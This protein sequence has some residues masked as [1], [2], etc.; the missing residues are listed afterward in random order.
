MGAADDPPGAPRKLVEVWVAHVCV[1][2]TL[3]PLGLLGADFAFASCF[4]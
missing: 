4:S 3:M 1:W 2:Y